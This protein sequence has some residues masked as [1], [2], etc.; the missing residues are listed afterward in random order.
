MQYIHTES[1][2][3]LPYNG[4]HEH[5]AYNGHAICN[6]QQ[7]RSVGSPCLAPSKHA[8]GPHSRYCQVLKPITYTYRYKQS[9]PYRSKFSVILADSHT[10]HKNLEVSLSQA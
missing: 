2:Q 9:L 8:H 6:V 5:M 3:A 10:L 4:H 7:K 1:Y